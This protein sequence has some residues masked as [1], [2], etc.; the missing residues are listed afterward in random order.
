MQH[1]PGGWHL[2]CVTGAFAVCGAVL[3]APIANGG[4]PPTTTHI[5]PAALAAAGRA[6]TLQSI[7]Y[8]SDYCD[9]E[10]TVE[11]WLNALVGHDAR[12]ITWTGGKCRLVNNMRPGFDAS[13]WPYCAQATIS[14]AHPKARGDEPMIEIYLEKPGHGHPGVAYAFRS[15]MMTRDDGLDYERFRKDFEAQWDERFPP[16]PAAPRCQD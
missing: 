12:A 7:D 8:G 11:A 4:E 9:S 14:L 3:T 5:S 15:L 1:E 16:D 13:S 2:K 6:A 10:T